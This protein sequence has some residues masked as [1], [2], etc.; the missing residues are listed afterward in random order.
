MSNDL[1]NDFLAS[2]R[3]VAFDT[4]TTGI[5]AAVNRLVEIAGVR[6]SLVDDTTETFSTLINPE[7]PIPPDAIAVHGITDE[8]VADSP[9]IATVM[10]QFLEFCSDA[11]LIAHNAPFDLAFLQWE[12]RRCNLTLPDLPAIDT[13]DICRK[14]FKGLGSYS[15]QSL[16][17]H[18]RLAEHQDHRALSDAELVRQLFQLA[19]P[20]FPEMTDIRGFRKISGLYSLADSSP[21]S[22]AIPEHLNDLQEALDAKG[23]VL[24]R[25][26]NSAGLET[27]R[28]IAPRWV[29]E[30]KNT[31]YVT[32]WCELTVEERTFRLDRIT[33][34]RL[35]TD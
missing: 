13:V 31:L 29:H 18:F 19:A 28:V 15:L 17:Q 35:V 5:W 34:I 2:L 4:E 27:E 22:I 24:I 21:V 32:A 14:L 16:M 1:G 3:F 8:M 12:G 9:T 30:Q 20:K 7:R 33:S 11:I 25:Y 6:F 10:P 26:R 23:K